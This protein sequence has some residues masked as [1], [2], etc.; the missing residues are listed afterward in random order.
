MFE[1]VWREMVLKECM[2]IVVFYNNVFIEKFCEEV[3]NN[4]VLFLK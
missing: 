2:L 1:I 4:F 3:D